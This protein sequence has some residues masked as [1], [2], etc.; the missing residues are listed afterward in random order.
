M[1]S[2]IAP[3]TFVQTGP[4]AEYYVK[5]TVTVTLRGETRTVEA[6][7]SVSSGQITAYGFTGRYET[8]SK[9]WP[10]SV[11]YVVD[12]KTNKPWD[13]VEFGRDERQGRCRKVIGMVW[14]K[15]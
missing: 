13:R 14:F 3:E 12:P 4:D 5:G 15:D 6:I 7:R 9:A 11:T 8:G 1:A 10:A 2:I